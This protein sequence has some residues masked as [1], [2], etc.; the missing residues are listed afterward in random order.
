MYFLF[1]LIVVYA[2]GLTPLYVIKVMEEESLLY[3][4]F[5]RKFQVE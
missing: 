2:R 4:I 5:I 3:N 1:L